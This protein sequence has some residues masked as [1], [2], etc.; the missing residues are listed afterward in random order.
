MIPY[1]L[2]LIQSQKK[3][4][5]HFMLSFYFKKMS[6]MYN[7]RASRWY[8]PH[9]LKLFIEVGGVTGCLKMF[10]ILPIKCILDSGPVSVFMCCTCLYGQALHFHARPPEGRSINCRSD[11]QSSIKSQKNI[12]F[13][14]TFYNILTY[15]VFIKYCVFSQRF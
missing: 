15:R 10:Q 7:G 12:I 2:A 9:E 14:N 11:M 5:S 4:V 1:L 13:M 3:V 8:H 6:S